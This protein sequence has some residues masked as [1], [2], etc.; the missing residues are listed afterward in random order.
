MKKFLLLTTA[1]VSVFYYSEKA[2]A[3]IHIEPLAGVILNGEFDGD[4]SFEGDL[5]GNVIGAK[6]GYRN[7]GLSLGLDIR[8]GSY[9]LDFEDFDDDDYVSNECGVFIG[10]DL[11]ILFRF[12]GTYHFAGEAERDDGDITLEKFSGFTVGVGYNLLPLIS[13]NLEYFSKNYEEADIDGGGTSDID[14][15]FTGLILGVS[16]PLSF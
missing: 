5:S 3:G 2:N 14:T 4:G 16:V 6:I 10:Y 1:L 7:L 11:P 9:N 8:R 13:L 15:E 12:W